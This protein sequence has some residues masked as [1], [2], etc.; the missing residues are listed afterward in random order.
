MGLQFVHR[1]G[2]TAQESLPALVKWLRAIYGTVENRRLGTGFAM[3]RPACTSY[4]LPSLV[5]APDETPPDPMEAMA[6]ARE[7]LRN[8]LLVA[9]IVDQGPPEEES[10]EV[11]EFLMGRNAIVDSFMSELKTLDSGDKREQYPFWTPSR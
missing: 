9:A 10:P 2:D 7:K 4:D 5:L 11:T 8:A 3:S 6:A 1:P